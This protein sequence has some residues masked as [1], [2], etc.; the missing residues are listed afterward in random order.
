MGS[1]MCIR[2]SFNMKNY[3]SSY[4]IGHPFLLNSK[5]F[6]KNNYNSKSK[7]RF[8]IK[9]VKDIEKYSA[10]FVMAIANTRVVRRTAELK[11]NNQTSYGPNFSYNEYMKT[12]SYTS[13]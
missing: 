3:K 6:I 13:A 2:D 4:K 9:Y 10:P 5:E 12:G 8:S 11:Q 7:D 1:E